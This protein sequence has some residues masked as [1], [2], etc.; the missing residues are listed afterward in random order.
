MLSSCSMSER[1]R[2]SAAI[3]TN[4]SSHQR[5]HNQATFALMGMVRWWSLCRDLPRPRC[6]AR[7]PSVTSFLRGTA[8]TGFH[9]NAIDLCNLLDNRDHRGAIW[10][11]IASK[12]CG[13]LSLQTR[14]QLLRSGCQAPTSFTLTRRSEPFRTDY[15]S[16]S[17][18]Q[19]TP[20]SISSGG[21]SNS[22]VTAS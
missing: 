20:A 13:T 4:P 7:D 3:W 8:T 10:S 16:M 19:R 11:A 12:L 1:C 22:V 14:L 15:N 6:G 5:C 17:L 21:L 2:T 18:L 9:A